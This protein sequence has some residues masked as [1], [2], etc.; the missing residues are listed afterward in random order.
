MA[1]V[2]GRQPESR[3]TIPRIGVR[4]LRNPR[5]MRV[6]VSLGP[7]SRGG[8][9]FRLGSRLVEMWRPPLVVFV[10]WGGGAGRGSGPS[11][12]P[13][14][15]GLLALAVRL[16]RWACG[17]GRLIIAALGTGLPR[18]HRLIGHGYGLLQFPGSRCGA[19]SGCKAVRRRPRCACELSGIDA[20]FEVARA[21]EAA[22]AYCSTPAIPSASHR[23]PGFG[24]TLVGLCKQVTRACCR[25]G[26]RVAPEA[27]YLL[28]GAPRPVDL[29][30]GRP[31]VRNACADTCS[32]LRSLPC[33][34]EAR[35]HKTRTAEARTGK[36]RRSE[37]RRGEVRRETK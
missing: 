16:V 10:V 3:A 35:R 1:T 22:S 27:V 25:H 17:R 23:P 33:Q 30:S 9:D 6:R 11:M 31:M 37:A 26:T 29:T 36:V 13:D 19:C 21:S 2:G 34:N 28:L 32:T 20:L 14:A 7:P 4:H 5:R 12:A 8:L 15:R 24:D 18:R